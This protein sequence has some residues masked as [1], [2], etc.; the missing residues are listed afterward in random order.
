MTKSFRETVSDLINFL[1]LKFPQTNIQF[2]QYG[3]LPSETPAILIYAEP[4]SEQTTSAGAKNARLMK[5]TIFALCGGNESTEVSIFESIELTE[6][7]E[8]AIN[9]FSRVNSIS[10][11]FSNTPLSFDAVYENIAASF[12]EFLTYYEVADV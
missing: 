5:F 10:V 9:E 4:Y 6:K 2:G 1:K 8:N 3:K 11:V 12:I 7:I